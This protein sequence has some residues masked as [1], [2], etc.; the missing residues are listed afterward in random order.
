MKAEGWWSI[1]YDDYIVKNYDLDA[2]LIGEDDLKA[3]K[4]G[5]KITRPSI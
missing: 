2:L 3:L 1:P 4:E 5:L